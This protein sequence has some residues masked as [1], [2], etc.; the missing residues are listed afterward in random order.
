M[1]NLPVRQSVPFAVVLVATAEVLPVVV[2]GWT[3]NGYGL[4]V[5]LGSVATYGIRLAG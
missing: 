4:A 2:P 3:D 5:L 1:V